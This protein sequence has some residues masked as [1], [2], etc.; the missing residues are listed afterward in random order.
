[1]NVTPES[2]LGIALGVGLAAATGLRVFVPLLVAGIAARAD[3]I[4]LSDSFAWLQSTPAL[5]TLGTAAIVEALAYL[6]PG[7]DHILDL[8]AGPAAVAAGI[9][10]SAGE[11]IGA[12]ALSFFAVALPFIC[13]IAVVALVVWIVRKARRLMFSRK[14]SGQTPAD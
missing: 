6:I 2:L 4:S 14:V 7:L 9:V 10:V 5:V 11:T 3:W 1:M 12:A 8:I 13:L